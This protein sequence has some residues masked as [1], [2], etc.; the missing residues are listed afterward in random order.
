M[1]ILTFPHAMVS[2]ALQEVDGLH[3]L[4][5]LHLQAYLDS[6]QALVTPYTPLRELN[7]KRKR[8]QLGLPV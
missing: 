1:V 5:L 6:S 3:R 7:L 8:E 4:E 2:A